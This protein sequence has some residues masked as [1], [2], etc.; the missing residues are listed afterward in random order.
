M[1]LKLS[2]AVLTA[3]LCSTALAANWQTSVFR[4]NSGN[5]VQPG[6]TKTEVLKAAGEPS[7]PKGKD[8]KGATRKAKVWTYRGSD[9][10]YTI[11]FAGDK[12]DHIEVTPNR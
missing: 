5:L 9:G 8:G 12:V 1:R 6:M 3:L 7:E 11:Y 10:I 4:T 2:A